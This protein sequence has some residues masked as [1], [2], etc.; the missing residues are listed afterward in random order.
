MPHKWSWS[1]SLLVSDQTLLLFSRSALTRTQPSSDMDMITQDFHESL[2][3]V[4]VLLSQRNPL[5]FSVVKNSTSVGQVG[6][7]HM[8]SSARTGSH[9]QWRA[10]GSPSI[11]NSAFE[12]KAGGSNAFEINA[13]GR[14][15]KRFSNKESIVIDSN[16]NSTQIVKSLAQA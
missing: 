11:T 6:I 3:H 4:T 13:V 15:V 14:E 10:L 9:V 16:F 2:S 7:D 8:A 1:A 12:S 5:P